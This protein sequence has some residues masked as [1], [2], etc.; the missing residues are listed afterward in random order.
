M[1]RTTEQKNPP[2]LPEGKFA[3]AC[4]GECRFGG[5]SGSRDKIRCERNG[6]W[7]DWDHVCSHFEE[8][9]YEPPDD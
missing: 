7:Y 1:E 4:C 6:H 2:V 5:Y 8:G 3:E 9:D